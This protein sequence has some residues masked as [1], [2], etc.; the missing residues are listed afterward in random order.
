MS[1]NNDVKDMHRQIG[2]AVPVPMSFELGK[3]LVEAMFENYLNSQQ[4]AESVPEVPQECL[5]VEEEVAVSEDELVLFQPKLKPVK[6]EKDEISETTLETHP[7]ALNDES[8]HVGVELIPK[9][10]LDAE[11]F[12]DVPNKER[13]LEE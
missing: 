11:V 3:R 7:T 9:A 2:N 4:T 1:V 5:P 10:R 6:L 12:V 8:P 13:V